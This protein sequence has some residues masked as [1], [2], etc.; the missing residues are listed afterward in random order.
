MAEGRNFAVPHRLAATAGRAWRKSQ[1]S[2]NN[3][4]K[5][6]PIF[7]TPVINQLKQKRSASVGAEAG[8]G[9]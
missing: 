8:P 5:P 6:N 4:T 9:G 2:K 1:E 3:K 7:G